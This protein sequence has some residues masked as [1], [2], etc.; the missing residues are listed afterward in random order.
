MFCRNCPWIVPTAEP[1][2]LCHLNPQRTEVVNIDEW[3]C[4]YHPERK[5]LSGSQ[6]ITNKKNNLDKHDDKSDKPSRNLIKN[7]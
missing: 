1:R 3:W 5:H 4:S 7:R 6:Y 2:G